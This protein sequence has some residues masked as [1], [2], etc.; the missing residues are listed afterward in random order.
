MTDAT[1]NESQPNNKYIN[2]TSSIKYLMGS[3]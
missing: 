3:R 1:Y 2:K